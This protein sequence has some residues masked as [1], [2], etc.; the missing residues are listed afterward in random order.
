MSKMP[1]KVKPIHKN[2]LME[3]FFRQDNRDLF[4]WPGIEHVES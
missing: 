4:P 2:D 3:K 1:N